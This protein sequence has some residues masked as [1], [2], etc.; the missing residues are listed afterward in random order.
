MLK[1][2]FLLALPLCAAGCVYVT[3]PQP[4]TLLLSNKEFPPTKVELAITANPDCNSRGPGF[5]ER[6]TLILQLDSTWVIE[7][8]AGDDVCWRR[9]RD[10]PWPEW[11]RSYL[12]P[13]RIVDSTL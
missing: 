3:G 12:A 11:N 4:G 9:D 5:F 8:P 7:A 6:A 10:P 13:G 1:R 2:L